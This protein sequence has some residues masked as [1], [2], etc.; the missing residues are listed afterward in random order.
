MFCFHFKAI[1]FIFI[2]FT[3]VGIVFFI[4]YSFSIID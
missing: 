1:L 2:F 4:I 3:I